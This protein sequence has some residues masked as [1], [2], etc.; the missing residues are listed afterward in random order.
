[1]GLTAKDFRFFFK[2]LKPRLLRED[3]ESLPSM[4]LFEWGGK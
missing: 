1:V 3:P 4:W 2:G